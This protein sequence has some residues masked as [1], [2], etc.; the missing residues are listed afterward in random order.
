MGGWV[1]GLTSLLW[2]EILVTLDIDMKHITYIKTVLPVNLK[3]RV[4]IRQYTDD[5]QLY[6]QTHCPT[7]SLTVF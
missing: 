1:D 3:A 2:A 6:L 4:S 5:T 7:P